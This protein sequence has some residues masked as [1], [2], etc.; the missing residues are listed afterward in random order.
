MCQAQ[1]PCGETLHFL[2]LVALK[3]SGK[4][5]ECDILLRKLVTTAP[6]ELNQRHFSVVIAAW[7]DS[8]HPLA[9]KKAAAV[10][11]LIEQMG[12]SPDIGSYT[13]LILACARSKTGD[14]AIPVERL[15]Q[16]VQQK[17]KDGDSTMQPNN[18]TYSAVLLGLGRSLNPNA[19]DLADS[20][21]RDMKDV[22]VRPKKFNYTNLM[23]SWAKHNRPDRVQ[24]TF[25]QMKE[26]FLEG[27]VELEPD[28]KSLIVRLQAWSKAGDPEMATAVLKE[29]ISMSASGFADQKPGTQEFST[30]LQAWMRSDRPNSAE[31]AEKGLK[32]MFHLAATK[33][34]ECQPDIFS[35][36]S[37]ISA[38]AKL[39]EATSL[40]KVMALLQCQTK[41]AP[42]I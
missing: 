36:T 2:A 35:F 3:R 34:F 16:E 11:K 26:G 4:R 42:S 31:T 18:Y 20:L 13:C 29:M 10:F 40:D 25:E 8:K 7:A 22:G 28:F 32:Q 5:G 41:P 12:M 15:F 39:N 14:P 37:V 33:R 19:L 23:V 38:Y 9:L 1:T 17:W 24:S 6:D 27:D 21:L 30:V